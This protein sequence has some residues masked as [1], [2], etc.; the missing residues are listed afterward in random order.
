MPSEQGSIERIKKS[1][2]EAKG[3]GLCLSFFSDGLDSFGA[4][5]IG[6]F[7]KSNTTV[8]DLELYGNKFTSVG[9]FLL[10]K[11]LKRNTGLIKL[12]LGGN[13]FNDGFVL[14]TLAEVVNSHPNLVFLELGDSEMGGNATFLLSKLATRR[15]P[16]PLIL[17][18][19][20]NDITDD[21][22]AASAQALEN[23]TSLTEINLSENEITSAG[24]SVLAKVL[25]KNNTLKV[26][27]LFANAIDYQGVLAL[28]EAL[29]INRTLTT[30]DLSSNEI[31]TS[32]DN[33]GKLGARIAEVLME[34]S[35]LTALLLNDLQLGNENI[36]S[37]VR[38]IRAN[39]S[40]TALGLE[41]N[42]ISDQTEAALVEALE[43]NI[44]LTK[45]E[46]DTKLRPQID[47]LLARNQLLQQRY[48]QPL[49]AASEKEDTAEIIRL[50]MQMKTA[51]PEIDNAN[52]KLP[53]QLVHFYWSVADEL[54]DSLFVSEGLNDK[55]RYSL[56]LELL[57]NRLNEEKYQKIVRACLKGL[58]RL[59]GA[60]ESDSDFEP[61]QSNQF[62]T[63]CQLRSAAQRVLTETIDT[64][65]QIKETHHHR[66]QLLRALC[67]QESYTPL[68]THYLL[69]SPE[70]RA[71][72]N[73]NDSDKPIVIDAVIVT[74]TD[75]S[76]NRLDKDA[77]I[78][79]M[80]DKID[81][82]H[83]AQLMLYGYTEA[84]KKFS[85]DTLPK[86]EHLLRH[87]VDRLTTELDDE[88]EHR[89]TSSS[90]KEEVDTEVT[91][92]YPNSLALKGVFGKSYVR[93]ESSSEDEEDPCPQKKTKFF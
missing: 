38:V 77:A 24:A 87:A 21:V 92:G 82:D 40:L 69:A 26:L 62:V 85:K 35:S 36:L 70:V 86:P 41:G 12:A 89:F 32:Q 28:F 8:T 60:Q 46:L 57:K 83:R 18:L 27:N 11:S 25:K 48:V 52:S 76:S 56:I 75:N 67:H 93:K 10:V 54:V 73:L 58:G 15:F 39:T 59:S 64:N 7:L 49:L 22:I 50:L 31:Y 29:K 2:E 72:L 71:Q 66:H 14:A 20:N 44:Y 5:L 23:N 4:D 33:Q 34:N 43:D 63:Y 17:I 91:P 30:I 61:H 16:K 6:K 79:V 68:A 3:P 81:P 65:G 88:K 1:L 37:F 78:L 84:V 90:G 51:Y 42:A 53:K 19:N 9:T 13:N 45:F 55:A 47:R 74:S 80:G